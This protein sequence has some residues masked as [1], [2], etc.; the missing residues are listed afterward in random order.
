MRH[1]A[2][3]FT[4]TRGGTQLE[5]VTGFIVCTIAVAM[6]GLRSLLRVASGALLS[7]LWPALLSYGSASSGADGTAWLKVRR[8]MCRYGGFR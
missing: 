5:C 8:R 2:V 6:I 3:G 7:W 1:G 4:S